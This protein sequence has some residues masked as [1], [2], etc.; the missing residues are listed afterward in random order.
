VGSAL[1]CTNPVLVNNAMEWSARPAMNM[2]GKFDAANPTAV[3]TQAVRH[4]VHQ[5][6]IPSDAAATHAQLLVRCSTYLC[7][8]RWRIQPLL[9]SYLKGECCTMQGSPVHE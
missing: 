7:W 9:N 4:S 8:T 6:M 5:M 1:Q 3:T 2:G